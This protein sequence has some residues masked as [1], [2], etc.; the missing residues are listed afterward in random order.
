MIGQEA[1]GWEWGMEMAVGSEEV[2]GVAGQS[3][4]I[5]PS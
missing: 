1:Q 5:I 4:V 2:G 3:F